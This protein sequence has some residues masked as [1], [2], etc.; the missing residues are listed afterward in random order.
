SYILIA[1][2]LVVEKKTHSVQIAFHVPGNG[3]GFL[4]RESGSSDNRTAEE[5]QRRHIEHPE[6]RPFGVCGFRG[7]KNRRLDGAFFQRRETGLADLNN[8]DVFIRV[9][10]EFLKQV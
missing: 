1:P 2:L 7:G 5:R 9:Q 10:A 8:S 3:I 6:T 4:R